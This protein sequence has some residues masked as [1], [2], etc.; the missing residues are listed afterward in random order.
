MTLLLNCRLQTVCSKGEENMGLQ[1]GKKQLA[2]LTM[3]LVAFT[4]GSVA[5]R[6]L[7]PG[8]VVAE[9][10]RVFELRIYHAMPGKLPVMESRFRDTTS[11]ILARH[12]LNVVGYWTTEDAKDN[13]FVFLLAHESRQ[14]ANKNWEAFRQDPA[15]QEVVKS[16]GIEKTLEKADIMWLRPTDFSPMK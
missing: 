1:W 16:E 14:E 11:K 10:S 8:A 5:T 15:F 12:N 7:L 9:N 4:A 3:S 13:S 6:L 2:L